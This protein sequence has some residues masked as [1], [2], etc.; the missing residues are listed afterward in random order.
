M[1]V[2]KRRWLA[3]VVLL[4][5]LPL[6]LPRGWCCIFAGPVKAAMTR[7]AP[8]RA[9]CCSCA[10][11]PA[12]ADPKKPDPPQPVKHCPCS[13]RDTTLLAGSAMGDTDLLPPEP[14]ADLTLPR[15]ALTVFLKTDSAYHFH[16]PPLHLLKC[17]WLC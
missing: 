7:S 12:S 6:I 3:A 17:L 15:E 11:G 4:C 8:P 16:A 5:S 14:V 13:D 9:R 10:G 2:M 1:R